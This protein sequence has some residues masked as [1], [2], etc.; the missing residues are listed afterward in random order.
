MERIDQRTVI[1]PPTNTFPTAAKSVREIREMAEFRVSV[2]P[3]VDEFVRF[4]SV[5]ISCRWLEEAAVPGSFCLGIT[6]S[7]VPIPLCVRKI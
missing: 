3:N 2:S 4:L 7:L 6:S 1:Q 5:L